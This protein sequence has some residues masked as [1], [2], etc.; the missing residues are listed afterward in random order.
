MI[1]ETL[2]EYLI[3]YVVGI[4]TMLLARHMRKYIDANNKL[5]KMSEDLNTELR[6]KYEDL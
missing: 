1:W 5:R 4:L 3:A 6:D 2:V